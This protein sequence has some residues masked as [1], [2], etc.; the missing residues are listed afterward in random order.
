[1]S[2][3]IKYSIALS[4]QAIC[5][6]AVAASSVNLGYNQTQ[7]ASRIDGEATITFPDEDSLNNSTLDT[8]QVAV[9]SFVCVKFWITLLIISSCLTVLDR[10]STTAAL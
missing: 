10:R 4:I 7:L 2:S 3:V 5:F 8:S 9:S 1:M 6:I